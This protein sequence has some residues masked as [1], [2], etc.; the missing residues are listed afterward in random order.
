M[1]DLTRRKFLH[2]VGIG[3]GTAVVASSSPVPASP[4]SLSGQEAGNQFAPAD[5]DSP[6]DRN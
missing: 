4:L 1:N 3:L 2:E 5:S 6:S